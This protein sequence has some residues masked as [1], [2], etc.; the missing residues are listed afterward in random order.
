MVKVYISDKSV[1]AVEKLELPWPGKH[2]GEWVPVLN[3]VCRWR[4]ITEVNQVVL[5]ISLRAI[6]ATEQ[7]QPY[8]KP[9]APTQDF[10]YVVV[11]ALKAEVGNRQVVELPPPPDELLVAEALATFALDEEE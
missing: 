9:N 6:R 2:I 10:H 5:P 8:L 3:E 4:E 11:S 7:M 1:E